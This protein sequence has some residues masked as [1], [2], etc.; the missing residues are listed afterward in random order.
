GDGGQRLPELTRLAGEDQWRLAAEVR[1]RLVERGG[2]GPRELLARGSGPPAVR[3]PR[4]EHPR[5][6]GC[7]ERVLHQ[8]YPLPGGACGGGWPDSRARRRI[9]SIC[10]CADICWVNSVAWMPWNRPS[11]QPTSWACAS[12]SS[13]S[14]GASPVNGSTT[15]QSSAFRSGDSTSSSSWI[16]RSWIS[17]N[18]R[19]P[20]SSI[21]ARRTSSTMLR[22]IGALRVSFLGRLTRSA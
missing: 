18:A 21:G 10:A 7:G 19:R 5:W 13:D 1:P 8:R 4:A 17:R 11:S 9:S 6:L 2:V 12:R 22:T 3:R 15:S 20:A 14:L 16:D